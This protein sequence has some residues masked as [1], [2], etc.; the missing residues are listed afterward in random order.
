MTSAVRDARNGQAFAERI[1]SEYG[2]DARVLTG[3]EEAQMTFL[4][5]MSGRPAD[6]SRPRRSQPS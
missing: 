3:E 2:L 4:G 6:K 1:R 5:A